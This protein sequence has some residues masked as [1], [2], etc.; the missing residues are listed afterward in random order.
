MTGADLTDT[1]I[2]AA[3]S[4]AGATLESC[5]GLDADAADQVGREPQDVVLDVGQLA[6]SPPH[7][8]PADIEEKDARADEPVTTHPQH[9]FADLEPATDAAHNVHPHE[10]GA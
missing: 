3:R 9:T 6:P 8:R 4:L 10:A 1:D 2:T 5:R 7:A